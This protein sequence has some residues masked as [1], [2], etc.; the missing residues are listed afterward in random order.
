MYF[1]GKKKQHSSS[2]SLSLLKSLGYYTKKIICNEF[3]GVL[4]MQISYHEPLCGKNASSFS[5]IWFKFNFGDIFPHLTQ[6]LESFCRNKQWL[7]GGIRGSVYNH[8]SIKV[9]EKMSTILI[10]GLKVSLGFSA[11]SNLCYAWQSFLETPLFLAT[12]ISRFQPSLHI[13]MARGT[14]NYHCSQGP[15]DLWY[16]FPESWWKPGLL[17]WL[18]VVYKL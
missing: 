9:S 10:P 2:A 13:K 3:Q 12:W 6:F 8:H 5:K 18:P 16:H 14:L 11:Q 17:T 15:N 7:G 4:W 1:L